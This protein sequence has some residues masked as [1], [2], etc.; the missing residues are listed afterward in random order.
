MTSLKDVLWPSIIVFVLLGISFPKIHKK[1]NV[2][3]RICVIINFFIFTGCLR[4]I[5]EWTST[6]IYLRYVSTDKYHPKRPY[7]WLNFVMQCVTC[8][9]DIIVLHQNKTRLRRLVDQLQDL[10]RPKEALQKATRSYNVKLALLTSLCLISVLYHTVQFSYSLLFVVC[11]LPFNWAAFSSATVL[12]TVLTIQSFTSH[13]FLDAVRQI[14]RS[15]S[16]LRR[17]KLLKTLSQDELQFR[18]IFQDLERIFSPILMLTLVSSMMSMTSGMAL[19]YQNESNAELGGHFIRLFVQIYSFCILLLIV[20]AN[21]DHN[22]KVN[23][24]VFNCIS[25]EKQFNK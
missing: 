4:T 2:I 25:L 6:T 20:K 19:I 8:V 18:K 14:H 17:R 13:R 16:P 1:S 15:K 23:S 21:G 22:R 10:T 11:I 5:Y 9:L 3:L 7:V 12:T 24:I